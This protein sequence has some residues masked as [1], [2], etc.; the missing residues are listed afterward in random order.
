M[1]SVFGIAAYVIQ[2]C[3]KHHYFISNLKLQK[4]L[5]FVQIDFLV[6]L[7]SCCFEEDIEA[8]DF[9]PVIP[10]I[11]DRYKDWG[12]SSIILKDETIPLICGKDRDRINDMVDECAKYTAAELVG[13]TQKQRPWKAAFH[14]NYH[15]VISKASLIEYFSDAGEKQMPEKGQ[16]DYKRD[17]NNTL[18]LLNEEILMTL[19]A[20]CRCIDQS[21]KI[22][23][24]YIYDFEGKLDGPK[25]ISYYE[26]MN[27]LRK[28]INMA[29]ENEEDG[30]IINI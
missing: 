25:E 2:Y 28:I 13:I 27:N 10:C 23:A 18:L 7:G 6:N 26:A 9:G 22:G 20:A 4:I 5:Y 30:K 21:D 3:V 29:E 11:Y 1:Y 15:N 12:N 24:T 17:E 14:R 19:R 8:W 16:E